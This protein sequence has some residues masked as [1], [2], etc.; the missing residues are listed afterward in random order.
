MPSIKL[1]VLSD[2]HAAPRG[3]DPRGTEVRLYSDGDAFGTHDNPM[4]S[5]HDL[6]KRRGLSADFVVC[7][8]DMTNRADGGALRYV[9][10]ELHA[11]KEALGAKEVIATVGNHDVDSRGKTLGNFPREALMRLVPRFPID[12]H[13]LADHYW[14]HGYYVTCIG[15]TRFLVLNSCWLHESRDELEMGAVTEYSLEKLKRDLVELG[16]ADINV[17]V[18]HHHPHVHS[19][20]GLGNDIMLNGQALLDVLANSG[21]WLVIH[22]H[23]HHPK[24][25]VAQGDFQAPVVL[26]CGSFSG[27]IEGPNATVS[28]NYFHLVEAQLFGDDNELCGAI[29]SWQW[30]SGLGWEAYGNANSSFPSRAGFGYNGSVK[31]LARLVATSLGTHQLM[32]WSEMLKLQPNLAYLTPKRFNAV[33]QALRDEHSININC[34]DNGLPSELG[35]RS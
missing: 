21:M 3:S 30:V 35:K 29:E 8:G 16:P 20:L 5:L 22:G 7:P 15:S 34:S 12:D 24:I 10:K 23:K 25:E 4:S 32:Q 28:R 13:K 1:A 14:A 33:L 18:C 9:W 11:L 31:T 26:A 27:R 17:A 2:L 19:E 6:I